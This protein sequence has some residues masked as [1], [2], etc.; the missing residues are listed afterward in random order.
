MAELEFVNTPEEIRESMQRFKSGLE[1]RH[2]RASNLAA[3][4]AYWVHDPDT[5]Q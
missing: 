4:T 2:N 1:T 3:T 5:R